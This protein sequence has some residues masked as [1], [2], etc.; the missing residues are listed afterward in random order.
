MFRSRKPV[1]TDLSVYMHEIEF[2][3]LRAVLEATAPRTCLEWGSGGSTQALLRECPFIERLVSVEHDPAWHAQVAARISD[4][5]LSLHLVE[6]DLP[7][8]AA[9]APREQIIAWD[10][11][12]ETDP[13]MMRSYVALPRGLK[14]EFD[15]VLVDGRARSFCVSEGFALLA[16]GGV[17]MLHDAQRPEYHAA[18]QRLGRAVFLEPW[19]QGQLCLL[20]K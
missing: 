14:L 3:Q 15:F 20:R 16:P 2:S 13:G 18:I 8:P 10:L 9:A 12:A 17:L 7:R 5:R 6:S 11:R 19:K 4:P 1:T